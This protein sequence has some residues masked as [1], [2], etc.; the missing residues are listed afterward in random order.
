M[1]L[2]GGDTNKNSDA[3]KWTR[4]SVATNRQDEET[5]AKKEA[6]F[7]DLSNPSV[8]LPLGLWS[9]ADFV[10][11]EQETIILQ[12]LD[13][14]KFLWEGFDQ[15]RRVQRHQLRDHCQDTP[16]SDEKDKDSTSTTPP[17][18]LELKDRLE[19]FTGRRVGDV[20]VQEYSK[21]QWEKTGDCAPN[22]VVATFESSTLCQ[23]RTR[24]IGDEDDSDSNNGN[25]NNINN[26]DCSCLVAQIPLRKSAIQ[27][28]NRPQRRHADCWTLETPN[29]WTDVHMEQRSLL[30]KTDDCL[31]NWRARVSAGPESSDSVLVLKFYSLPDSSGSENKTTHQAGDNIFGY[32]P[33]DQ[34]QIRRSSLAPP[35]ADMLTIIVTTSPIKSNPSMEV[36]ERTMETF[37]HAGP[38]FAYKCRKVFVCDGV[39]R[40]DDGSN[41]SRKHNNAKQSMRNGIVNSDQADNYQQFKNILRQ[42][43]ASASETSPYF[44]GVVEELETRQGYGFALKHA[45]QH[46][47][48]TPFVCVIQHDRTFMRPTPIN[49]TMKAM[50]RNPNIKYVGMSQRSNLMYK[51]IFV[52]K[53]GR[54]AGDE[55]NE[56]V[57]LVPELSVDAAKYGPNSESTTAMMYANE[58]L[59][60]NTLALAETYRKSAQFVELG[61]IL[62]QHPVESGKHQLTL[63]PTL[64]WYDNTHICDT[65]HYRDF[66]FHPS[67]KMVAKGG[68]VEDKLSPVIKR[69]V[70][71]L[72]LKDGH[73]RF[74]SY[75]LD[76][77]SGM[78]FTGHLDGGSYMTAAERV[79]LLESQS[80]T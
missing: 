21:R 48:D 29:H 28:L 36:I 27:H 32:V 38:D 61:E 17:S 1:A 12:E 37:I 80:S 14:N 8:H 65:A 34:D 59:R 50:W 53:Y 58:R 71:R 23:C 35:L 22:H 20:V 70:E 9:V 67:Y 26:K 31:W 60:E 43:C 51:D 2:P 55:L 72:G 47:V 62:E 3:A 40:Q 11:E 30:V 56:M 76:D 39:R 24:P 45:L 19:N 10:T 33:S 54:I 57:Q 46:C 77:R 75:L 16:T 4:V 79:D 44:N 15:R 25:S 52:A 41:V 63:T 64:F 18:L 74:G 69:T 7:L 68:F 73:S 42:L 49:E 13:E 78:F 6:C 5:R 66:V